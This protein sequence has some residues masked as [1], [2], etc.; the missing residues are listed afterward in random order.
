[1]KRIE[2]FA[3]ITSLFKFKTITDEQGN[4]FVLFAQSNYDFVE[5]IKD[6]T[7]FEAYENHVHLIDNIKKN[8][9]N[10]LI[11]IARDLGQTMFLRIS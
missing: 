10:K 8:E 2:Y 5:N 9:L 4:E 1:M 3:V 7:D 6:R 11:P